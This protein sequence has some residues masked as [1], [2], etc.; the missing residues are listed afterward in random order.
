METDIL[1]EKVLHRARLAKEASKKLGSLSSVEKRKGLLLMGE[2]L[3]KHREEI[4][5]ANRMDLQRAKEAGMAEGRQDRLRIT[6]ER[7]K[8][9]IR[10]L[11]QVAALPDPVGE[12]LERIERPN[13][14]Q[15]EKVRVPFGVIAMIYESRPN[16]TVDAVALALK[17]GNA[18]VLKGGREALQSNSALVHV[19]REGLKGTEIPLEAIQLIGETE[20]EAVEI[21]IRA[22]GLVDLAIPRGG[23]GLIQM[24]IE[25]SLV[26]VIETGV[27]NC[28]IYV[29]R[30]ADMDKATS[31]L[32]NGKTQRP[33][34]CNAAETLLVHREIAER[35]LPLAARE[36]HRRGVELRGCPETVSILNEAGF[37]E[38]KEATEEDYATEFL[39]LILAVKVVNSVE[40][41]VEHIEKY[42]T[43][44]SEAIVTEDGEAARL[45]LNHVDAAA[46]YHNAS[47]RFT[48]GFEFGFGAE[49]GISTQKLHA[50]GP[51]GLKELT[52]YK[53]IIHGNGQIR[54]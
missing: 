27:G 43:K 20:R 34:V 53:Y 46:V 40:E 39:D 2:A 41:A 8:G 47:T 23:A 29:D 17:T 7:L 22:K 16:V 28:H 37:T 31:I 21:L 36:L 44:H 13:G 30:A 4:Y 52:S 26:P 14:L 11:E 42:G 15:I 18:V 38:V 1:K 12:V 9:I 33:S 49:M 19:L 5:E 35:W 10:G 51:M 6:E 24:V 50:R 45:F 48:D 25:R 32:I 3:W 54:E